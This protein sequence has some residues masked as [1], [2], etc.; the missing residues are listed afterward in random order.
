LLAL[1]FGFKII[2]L[3]NLE[4]AYVLIG[5]KCF[6]TEHPENPILPERDRKKRVPFNNKKTNFYS[7]DCDFIM[8]CTFQFLANDPVSN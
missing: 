8:S 3:I 5:I 2:R 1:N 7:S 4:F 6:L